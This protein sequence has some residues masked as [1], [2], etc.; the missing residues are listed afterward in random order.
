MARIS[1]VP[2]AARN[3]SIRSEIL[4]QPNLLSL[5]Q[6]D[7]SVGVGQTALTDGDQRGALAL[8]RLET[9]LVAF[10][11]A[12]ELQGA[13]VT[14]SQ[15]TANWLGNVGLMA[16]RATNLEEDNQALQL[17][18]DQRQADVS[19]VNMDEELANL[20]VFQNAYNAAARVLSSVQELY[21]ELLNVV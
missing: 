10:D 13:S 1:P 21:D 11:D 2:I 16:R 6:F 19:G 20:I 18:I 12:G 17:E 15:Y 5:G 3:L 7:Q 9:T 8:Q 14:L 4:D